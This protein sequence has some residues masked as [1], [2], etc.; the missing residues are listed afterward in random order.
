MGAAAGAGVHA[1]SHVIDHDLGG[2]D[3]DAPLLAAFALL[4]VA[5]ALARW[6][7]VERES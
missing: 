5:G 1:L 7:A 6:N 2:K 4:L 3:T